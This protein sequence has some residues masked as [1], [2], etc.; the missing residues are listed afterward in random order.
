VTTASPTTVTL[1]LTAPV[2][3]SDVADLQGAFAPTGS[4]TFTLVG[5]GGF[6]YTQTDPVSG[7]GTY[8]ASTT[9]PTTGT[10][11]GTYTWSVTYGGDGN[12]NGAND[13]G[14]TSEE[15][16]VGAASLTLVTL[17][18]Q[19]TL[20]L[21]G[22]GPV[23]LTDAAFL[24]G[25]QAPTGS[26]VFTLSG[27]GGFSYT[28]TDPV[29]GDGTYT[30]STTLPTTGTVAGTYTWTARYS[31]DA[32]NNPAND[33]GGIAEQTVV[34]PA[35]PSVVTTASQDFA[36]DTT[37]PTLTD[38]AALSG[39][40]FPTGSIVFTLTGPGGFSYTQPEP[41]NGDG[42]YTA[43]TTL[44][45]TGLVA[46]T[47]TWTVTYGGDANN[48]SA[49][50]QGGTDEQTVVS[51]A[52]PSIATAASSA[53]TLGTTAPTLSDSAV[54]SGGYFPTGSITFMLTG[55][56]GFSYTQTDA[57]NGNGTY[58]ASTL[59]PTTAVV[60]GTYTWTAHYSGDANNNAA[61]DQGG[62]AEQTLVSPAS[63]TV[64]TTASPTTVTLTP[65]TIT[66]PPLLT[67]SAVL[68]GGYFPTGS[69]VFTLTGPGGFAYTQT[70][71]VNGNNTYTAS[72]TLPTTGLVAGT[73]TWTAHYTGDANNVTASDQGGTQEQ[74]SVAP[75]SATL[76]TTPSP[77][78]VRL[79]AATPPLLTDSA[80]LT[81]GFNPTGTI[82]FTLLLGGTLVDT[83]SVAVSG[84][85]TY[86]TPTGYQ[87][88][89]SGTV[90]G[91]YQWNATY[92]GDANNNT[93]SDSN[94]G[95]EQVT[96]S[97]AS[98]TITT[99]PNPTTARLGVTLQDL[100]NLA[101]G[102]SPTG[103]ITFALYA[104][105]VDPTVGP[106]AYTETVRGV[107]GNG[108]Y[109]T[110]A[111]FA[112]NV[113]GVW[114]WVATYNG[115]A[116]NNATPSG[117]LN[118]PVTIP[119]QAD[120]SLTKTVDNATAAVG[121]TVTFTVTLTNHGPDT[122]TN[123]TVSDVL[124]AGLTL[125]S[126]KASQGTY[127]GGVWSVG[128][129][130]TSVAP[131]LT[132]VAQ[133]VSPKPQTNTATITHSDQFDPDAGNDSASA[134]VT[135]PQ[136]DLTL[137]K[138]VNQSQVFLG[139]KVTY[140]FVIRNLGPGTATGV[141]VNDPI[142]PGLV[143]VS[144]AVP[145]QG[146]YNAAKGIWNVGTLTNGAVATLRVTCQVVKLGPVVNSAFA[147]GMELDP[148]L[149]NNLASAT[150]LGLNPISSISKRSFLASAF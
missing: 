92:S 104:P 13:Q 82:T 19:T 34:S 123:V 39:G 111:G 130:T 129:V 112:T 124:P 46:G 136:A 81:G 118:E 49:H 132:L 94:N 121:A 127:Q 114:H 57:V 26:M 107:S 45:T 97:P 139:T 8:T 50:D 24:S 109:Q 80:T 48:N 98:P 44:P 14:G 54:L 2:A 116:N 126:S 120:L 90:A 10:V 102:Y 43:S 131:T 86:A 36:L 138:K 78:T 1:P 144:A 141:V 51:P 12:N 63:P 62:V 145:S 71:S 108:T 142:P 96:V 37:A 64:V 115:D 101:G 38:T 84:N 146:T 85:G 147:S 79:G 67:D 99:T 16:V 105:G 32:N 83:E 7:N 25:G 21:A 27:P 110:S 74:V 61:D 100:A 59:L 30:A 76:V 65:G 5:P 41:V 95:A 88:P 40:Y 133:V 53:V 69:I 9:L 93:A 6:S 125:L 55:P 73:Y 22:G 140:T 11:A 149:A 122:A 106:A 35:S 29:N 31:G 148:D 87:L 103:S 89:G 33:Q 20:R 18:G 15:T 60:A 91:T 3:L 72:T 134:T 28:Q 47:Y 117:P 66:S 119:P 128:T 23:T 4:I 70:D 113:T 58:T 137:S 56:G 77:S 143:F 17:A 75:A 42:T 150:V 135:P 68:S 52:D